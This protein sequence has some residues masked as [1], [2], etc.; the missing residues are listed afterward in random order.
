MLASF[1]LI[2]LGIFLSIYSLFIKKEPVFI[3][4]WL[5]F[6]FSLMFFIWLLSLTPLTE[7]AEERA[8]RI[9]SFILAALIIGLI[10]LIIG[11]PLTHF[12]FR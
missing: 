9:F 1:L 6:Y 4:G 3:F 10:F 8:M 2:L 5:L 7:T 12:Y 11:Y